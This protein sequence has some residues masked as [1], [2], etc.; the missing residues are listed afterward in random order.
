MKLTYWVNKGL[1]G[2]KCFVEEFDSRDGLLAPIYGEAMME[3]CF[4]LGKGYDTEFDMHVY[5][6]N[7]EELRKALEYLD[8]LVSNA[9]AKKM[10]RLWYDL[11]RELRDD[12]FK[13]LVIA[14]EYE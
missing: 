8:I 6:L 3:R 5:V 14:F 4:H 2:E 10:T 11:D 13:I 1:E 12:G 9:K 7:K